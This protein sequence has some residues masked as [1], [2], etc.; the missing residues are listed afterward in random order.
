MAMTQTEIN[1]LRV[2]VR[3]RLIER[4]ESVEFWNVLIEVIYDLSFLRTN[5]FGGCGAAADNIKART[6][7]LM[8]KTD[9]LLG[10]ELL[11]VVITGDLKRKDL[12]L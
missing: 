8:Q 2:K 6:A 4:G 1:A 12:I 5:V 10:P 3:R 11:K 7:I 9:A